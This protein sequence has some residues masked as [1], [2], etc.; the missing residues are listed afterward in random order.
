MVTKVPD[1]SYYVGSGVTKA[2]GTYRCG[3]RGGLLAGRLAAGLWVRR[4]YAQALEPEH[5]PRGADAGG[6]NTCGKRGDLLAGRLATSLWVRR[7]HDQAL[8]P[9]HGPKI[10][11]AHV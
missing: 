8:E 10:G 7:P 5:G 9:E 11:R 1:Y 3:V 4:P 6:T 2:G